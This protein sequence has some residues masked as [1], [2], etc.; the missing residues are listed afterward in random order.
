M[1]GVFVV[2]VVD[3]FLKHLKIQILTWKFNLSKSNL[4]AAQSPDAGLPNPTLEMLV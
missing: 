2:V 1:P 3:L 4:L